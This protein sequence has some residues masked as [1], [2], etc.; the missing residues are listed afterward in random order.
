MASYQVLALAVAAI[1]IEII[2]SDD[3]KPIFICA[4]AFLPFTVLEYRQSWLL[5]FL[6]AV[7][8][9]LGI[10][11]LIRIAIGVQHHL[12][13]LVLLLDILAL[14]SVGL[15]LFETFLPHLFGPIS[16]HP[17]RWRAFDSDEIQ[18][19]VFGVFVLQFVLLF[20]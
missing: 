19:D 4:V 14:R 7:S 2:L 18:I 10:A 6:I 11:V 20:G 1:L 8:F 9:V 17:L 3:V 12:F 15:I 5:F 13:L 16:H